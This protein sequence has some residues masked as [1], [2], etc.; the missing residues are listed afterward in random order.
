MMKIFKK[1]FKPAKNIT[2]AFRPSC[3]DCKYYGNV[4]SE[5]KL[6]PDKTITRGKIKYEFCSKGKFHLHDYEPCGFFKLLCEGDR[7][8]FG[9]GI[10]PPPPSRRSMDKQDRE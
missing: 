1:I 8:S 4:K 9:I 5:D 3:L 10:I 2:K 6:N 7:R